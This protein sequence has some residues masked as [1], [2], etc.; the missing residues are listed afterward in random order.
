MIFSKTQLL[1]AVAAAGLLVPA[2]AI[3]ATINGGPAGERLRGTSLADTING[4][5]GNDRIR[6]FAGP[7]QLN[8]GPGNDRVFA[9]DRRDP[10]RSRHDWLHRRPG[11]DAQTTNTTPANARPFDSMFG[12]A[13]NEA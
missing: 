8:G 1:A 6:G 10:R 2:T 11:D 12:A 9:A 3:A 4:N 5:G 7:D 13:G